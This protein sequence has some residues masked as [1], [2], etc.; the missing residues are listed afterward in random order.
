MF[1]EDNTSS[2]NDLEML[3]SGEYKASMVV[4]MDEF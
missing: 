4:W 1:M 2:G 3:L